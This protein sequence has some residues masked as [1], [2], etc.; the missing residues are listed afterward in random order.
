[1]NRMVGDLLDFTRSR[2]GSGVP[3]VRKPM[4][5]AKEASNAVDEISAA[6][7]TCVL[8]LETSGDLRGSWDC[9]RL[10][11]VLANLLGNAVHHGSAATPITVEVRGDD[12]GVLLRV[13]NRG[14]SIPAAEIPG[15]F[16]PFK[17]LRSGDEF[18]GASSSLGLGLYIAERIVTAHGGQIDVT[19]SDDA[20]TTFT[21]RLP[22]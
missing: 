21:V 13:H 9:A 20:G 14:P 18:V 2:L 11:Q 3:V 7:P 6:H 1:M 4:D 10:G 8:N 12:A 16:G 19:S 15:L 22:R 17:R 5:L